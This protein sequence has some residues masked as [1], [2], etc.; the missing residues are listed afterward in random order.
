MSNKQFDITLV[1]MF[2]YL[3]VITEWLRVFNHYAQPNFI[4]LLLQFLTLANTSN[5]TR[6]F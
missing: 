1:V 6:R 5:L 2:K 4:E 3:Q